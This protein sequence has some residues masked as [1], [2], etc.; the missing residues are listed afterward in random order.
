MAVDKNLKEKFDQG[1][2][3]SIWSENG[4]LSYLIKDGLDVDEY[5]IIIKQ[6][7]ESEKEIA[8]DFSGTV[9]NE[10]RT[11]TAKF[12]YKSGWFLEGLADGEIQ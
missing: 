9:S 11:Y 8:H 7:L 2:L 1:I 6:V 12:D 10:S 4:E 5:A 3:E